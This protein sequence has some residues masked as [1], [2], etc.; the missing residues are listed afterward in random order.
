MH[1]VLILIGVSLALPTLCLLFLLAARR[2]AQ[3][4]I[5]HALDYEPED[6]DTQHLVENNEN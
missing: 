5:D 6:V 3:R 4:R 2:F 1:P